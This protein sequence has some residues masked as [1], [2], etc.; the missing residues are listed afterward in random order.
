MSSQNY[1]DYWKITLEYTNI[2][3]PR[4]IGT[5]LTI[6]NFIDNNIGTEY[7][8][9]KYKDLQIKLN[10]QFKKTD[11]GSIRKSINQFVK[12]GF[13]NFELRSYH[14]DAKDFIE[15]KSSRKRRSLFSKIVY[16]N[17]SFKRSV[18]NDS[19]EREINFLIK[20]LEENGKLDRKDV[21][22]LMI[23]DINDYK[24]GYLTSEELKRARDF[25]DSIGFID[26]K[27]NQLSYLW[28]I[29]S[30]LDDVVI[31]DN[32]IY[33]ENDAKVIENTNRK[34]ETERDPYL[35]R[36]YKNNLKEESYEYQKG[37][38]CM[39]E[40]LAYPTL[41][42]SHIKPYIQASDEEAYDPNNGLLLSQ[43]IDGLF[44]KGYI[45]FND[46][47]SIIVSAS[48]DSELQLKLRQYKL[49]EFYL[50]VE[51]IKYLNIHRTLYKEKLGIL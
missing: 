10:Q 51:R 47:G 39:V 43:N 14:Q 11:M 12:L 35:H 3:G 50:K 46:D 6:I 37:V 32:K 15:A 4:F 41:V 29:I 44:D 30:K 5:L 34:I 33:F 9:A 17:S 27:Y 23:I 13:I 49:E 24:K 42:A 40:K 38:K 16:T 22:S 7:T 28:G 36:L 1:E 20:T 31:H 25:A 45:S 21:V 2:N 18:T 8:E 19:N 48:L 26:R